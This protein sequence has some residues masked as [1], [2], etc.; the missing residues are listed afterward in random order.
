M[1]NFLDKF[2]LP[3][4]LILIIGLVVGAYFII[5][6]TDKQDVN[7]S[8]NKLVIDVAGA[9]N[10]PDIY[11]FNQEA[12]VEDAIKAAGG[13]T[14]Q[15]DMDLIYKTINRAALLQNHGKIY[16]PFI[17]NVKDN[18]QPEQSNQNQSNLININTAD[19]KLLDILPGIGPIT[20]ERI[21]EYRENKGQ[22]QRK[23]D[24]MKVEGISISKYNKL[25]DLI[26][27]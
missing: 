4:G 19:N 9:I 12:I 7:L 1:N 13:F 18:N 22:Y 16:I 2:A 20:A 6:K 26:T 24:L 23:E 8:N 14:D 11:T 15:A 17:E 10:N 25:K 21:I 27:I 5:N 3:I